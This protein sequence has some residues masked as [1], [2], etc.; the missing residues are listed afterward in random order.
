QYDYAIALTDMAEFAEA[1]AELR[2][3][4]QHFAAEHGAT[5]MNAGNV[6]AA[7]GRLLMETGRFDEADKQLEVARSIYAKWVHD[8]NGAVLGLNL[9][10]ALADVRR[11]RADAAVATLTRSVKVL[12][13]WTS[14]E[15][16]QTAP[17][18]EAL[19]QAYVEL[20]RND[21]ALAELK[22]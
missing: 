6:H 15:T 2:E 4:E 9:Y 1:D 5:D 17:F 21:D 8:D 10:Q 18:R 13:G 7:M 22:M 11:D 20:Q 19:S 14:G 16:D 3:A 12:D